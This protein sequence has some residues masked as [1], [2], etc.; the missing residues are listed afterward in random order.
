MNNA[1]I[2]GRFHCSKKA[3]KHYCIGIYSVFAEFVCQ[4]WCGDEKHVISALSPCGTLSCD[5]ILKPSLVNSLAGVLLLFRYE[6]HNFLMLSRLTF[7]LIKIHSLLIFKAF[8]DTAASM[9]DSSPA[10]VCC[11]PAA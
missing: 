10:H 8:P 1:N 9:P 5:K 3:G 4:W 7:L 2:C 11:V 6:K